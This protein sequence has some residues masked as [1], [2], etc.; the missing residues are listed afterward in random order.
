MAETTDTIPTP[1]RRRLAGAAAA[2]LAVAA[3]PTKAAPTHPP[4]A[5]LRDLAH[6][7]HGADAANLDPAGLDDELI[8]RCRAYLAAVV[9]YNSAPGGYFDADDD[10]LWQSVQAADAAVQALP[11]QTVVGVVEKA[12]IAVALAS[13]E[14][15]GDGGWSNGPAGDFAH[16]LTLDLNRLFVLGGAA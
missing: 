10:P 16:A 2:A 6:P 5:L 13:Q 1:A 15:G 11:P 7:M 12:R 14:P 3:L 8:R 9:T 4:H